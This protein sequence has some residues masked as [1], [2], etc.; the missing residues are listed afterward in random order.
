MPNPSAKRVLVIAPT[1]PWQMLFQDAA[2]RRTYFTGSRP[3]HVWNAV[4]DYKPTVVIVV[5]PAVWPAYTYGGVVA[6]CNRF[7]YKVV[8]H[9]RDRSLQNLE[10]A[11][12]ELGVD[13]ITPQA[14]ALANLMTYM[15][16][17]ETAHYDRVMREKDTDEPTV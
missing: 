8:A 3:E 11:A 12:T 17:L 13:E 1:L 10:R 14:E 5:K 6:L 16:E 4:A 7:L 2:C 15:D 9:G